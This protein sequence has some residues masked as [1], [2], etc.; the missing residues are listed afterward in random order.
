MINALCLTQLIGLIFESVYG[1]NIQSISTNHGSLFG[2]R[3]YKGCAA[4]FLIPTRLR[5]VKNLPSSLSCCLSFHYP[6]RPNLNPPQH[7]GPNTL[8]WCG[9][10][11][12]SPHRKRAGKGGGGPYGCLSFD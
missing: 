7:L 3:E 4:M 2:N 12:G 9:G 1:G 11:V 10:M 5:F 8:T 6:P